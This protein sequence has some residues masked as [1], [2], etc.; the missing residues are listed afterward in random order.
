MIITAADVAHRLTEQLHEKGYEV[1]VATSDPAGDFRAT[2][3][4]IAAALRLPETAGTNLD[5]LEDSLHDLEQ[6]WGR[7]VA[8]LWQDA[9]RLAR[10][11]GDRWWILAEILDAADLPVIAARE[12]EPVPAE[13]TKA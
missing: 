12:A 5:A 10:S 6:I 4:A 13:E 11:D 7:P 1:A 9:S 3:A 8:L 2:Q